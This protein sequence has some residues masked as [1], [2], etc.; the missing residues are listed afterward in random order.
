SN[1]IHGTPLQ[2]QFNH[3]RLIDS[4]VA[5]Y[6][7]SIGIGNGNENFTYIQIGSDGVR[8]SVGPF[9][10]V[11]V[12]AP[13]DNHAYHCICIAVTQDWA[14]EQRNRLERSWLRQVY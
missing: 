14:G 6:L 8:V 11:G 9:V 10:G 3:W 1:A 5:N 12:G 4:V 13:V 7:A 2:G